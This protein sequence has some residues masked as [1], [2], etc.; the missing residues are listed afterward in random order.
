MRPRSHSQCRRPHPK[1]DAWPQPA[2]IAD[3]SFGKVPGRIRMIAIG[4]CTVCAAALLVAATAA[5][6]AQ[7]PAACQTV[8]FSAEVLARFPRIREACLDVISR[9]DV[10]YAVVKAYLVRTSSSGITV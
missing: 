4:R 5:V 6:D 8:Q 1:S 2:A 3:P 10:K 7:Q 9:D